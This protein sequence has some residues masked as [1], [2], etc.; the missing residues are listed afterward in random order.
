[1]QNLYMMAAL[2]REQQMR[3]MAIEIIRGNINIEQAMVRYNVSTKEHVIARV[4]ALKQ[5]NRRKA[6]SHQQDNFPAGIL[7]A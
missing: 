5:E 2:V 6:E 7:A 4:E 3:K 1:M